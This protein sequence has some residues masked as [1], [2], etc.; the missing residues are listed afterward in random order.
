MITLEQYKKEKIAINTRTQEE[1][2]S[3]MSFFDSKDIEWGSHKA[4]KKKIF[5]YNKDETCIEFEKNID[6]LDYCVKRHYEIFSYKIILPTDLVEYNEFMKEKYI[7]T[8]SELLKLHGRSVTC[9]IYGKDIEDVKIKVQKNNDVYIV[10]NNRDEFGHMVSQLISWGNKI[11][12]ICTEIKLKEETPL[13]DLTVTVPLNFFENQTQNLTIGQS[14]DYMLKSEENVIEYY[15]TI[16]S[17]ELKIKIIKGEFHWLE[18]NG[19]WVVF[20]PY[21]NGWTKIK[22]HIEPTTKEKTLEDKLENKEHFEYEGKQ[23]RFDKNGA[24]ITRKGHNVSL[25]FIKELL[26]DIEIEDMPVCFG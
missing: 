25:E 18:F 19:N 14:I 15:D 22:K 1:Y 13:K 12:S 11:N 23:Y 17:K 6:V 5:H 9:K 24:I 16:E 8:H 21:L 26:E 2:D 3:L 10:Q 20:D 7:T 4:S